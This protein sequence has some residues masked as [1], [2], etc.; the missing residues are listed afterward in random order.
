MKVLIMGCGRVGSYI[1]STLWHDGCKVT[2]VDSQAE[3][4]FLLPTDMRNQG[5]C[6]IVGDGVLEEVMR[7]AGVVESD[8][9]VAVTSQDNRHI[10][11]TQ[12]AKHLFGVPRVVCRIGD[13][14][15]QEVYSNLGLNVV[16]STRVASNL[17]L[18]AI[19]L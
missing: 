8:V 16:S 15:R 2:I 18:E 19:R 5:D 12:K 10:L 13:P 9:F 7:R 3:S 4:F 6:T 1:A 17:I 14:M 11:A